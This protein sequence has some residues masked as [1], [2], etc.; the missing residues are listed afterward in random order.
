MRAR[1]ATLPRARLGTV[2]DEIG[3]VFTFALRHR[4]HDLT[5]SGNDPGVWK[6]VL[7]VSVVALALAAG[8]SALGLPG[9]WTHAEI[10]YFAGGAPHTLVLDRGLVTSASSSSLTLREQDGSSVTVPLSA[11]TTQVIVNG[12]PGSLSSLRRGEHATTQ[13]VDGGP[14]LILQL[15][16]PPRLL[17]R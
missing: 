4:D 1:A 15:R 11:Q 3:C 13:R 9:G 7:I 17:R 6:P 12:S 14:A 10:N 16:V 2:R 5:A 8:S